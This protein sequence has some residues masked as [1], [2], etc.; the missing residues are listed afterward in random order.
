[1][2][3]GNVAV[4][5]RATDNVAVTR[6]NLLVNGVVVGSSTSAPFTIRWN[7]QKISRESYISQGQAFDAAGNSAG[8][9][10]VMVMR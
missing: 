4:T 8:S 1:M 3:S 6:V 2:V 9:A 7:T 10:T 5:F